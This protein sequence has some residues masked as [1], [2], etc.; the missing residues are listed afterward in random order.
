MARVIYDGKAIIPAPLV[1]VT[2]D[3]IRTQDGT[4]ISALWGIELTGTALPFRG[5]PSGNFVSPTGAFWTLAGDPPDET[6]ADN[7]G[8][9]SSLV[10]KEE[11]LRYL[12]SFDGQLLELYAGAS[13]ATI[14]CNPRV[15]SVEFSSGQ[16]VDRLEYSIRLEADWVQIAGLAKSTE[17][18]FEVELISD[19]Q[20]KWSFNEVTGQSGVIQEVSHTITAQGILGYDATGLPYSGAGETAGGEAWKHAKTWC[21][22]RVLG[23]VDP[24]VMLAVLGVTGL[25]GGSYVKSSSMGELDGEY[26]VT[27]E[28]VLSPQN[29]FIEKSFSYNRN[30]DGVISVDYDGKIMGLEDGEATGGPLAIANAKAAIPSDATAKTETEQALLGMLGTFVLGVSPSEK[31]I[32]IDNGTAVIDFSFGWTADDEEEYTRK[33]EAGLSFNINDSTYTLTYSCDIEGHGDTPE[34]RLANAELGILND[35]DARA[36]AIAL[37]GTSLP[38][39]V[40]IATDF[41]SSSVSKN[42]T[43]GSV[44]F[45]YS[46]KNDDDEFGKYEI[47]IDIDFPHD[48]VAVLPIPGRGAGPIIQDMETVTQQIVTV[49]LNSPGNEIKPDNATIIGIMNAAADYVGTWFLQNDKESYSPTSKKY[50]RTRSYLVD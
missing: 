6:F 44:R 1:Q 37:I 22:N 48:V 28:W 38:V 24:D 16:W 17:D 4:K 30:R 3:Y 47:S 21:D 42:E 19:G 5:S 50:T 46:W 39:G 27:E 33:C 49:S 40:T 15:V 43:E 25:I 35:V 2:K 31:K 9:F 14:R 10:K 29:Y 8:A 32:V 23:F 7:D 12:F 26:S 41:Q 36:A 18:T 45:S 11:A 13:P 20:E 34:D